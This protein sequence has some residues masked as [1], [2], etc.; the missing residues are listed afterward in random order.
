[1]GSKH[2][3][4]KDGDAANGRQHEGVKKKYEEE[5][6]KIR[7]Q[8]FKR[9]GEPHVLDAAG[10]RDILSVPYLDIDRAIENPNTFVLDS[11]NQS[12]IFTDAS[13]VIFS[14]SDGTVD[15]KPTMA[16]TAFSTMPLLPQN[17]TKEEL[18]EQGKK[19][20]EEIK[21]MKEKLEDAKKENRIVEVEKPVYEF[22]PRHLL[23]ASEVEGTSDAMHLLDRV[24]KAGARLK[25][26]CAACG[27]CLH[28]V[29][30]IVDAD[31]L[32]SLMRQVRESGMVKCRE[33]DAGNFP[34]VFQGKLVFACVAN[35]SMRQARFDYPKGRK[36]GSSGSPARG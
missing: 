18:E 2:D 35:H 13:S 19:I 28:E 21:S 5:K 30:R 14:P 11:S 8:F 15:I 24:N 33:C 9:S 12:S 7:K 32:R 16:P 36:H 26:S 17:A 31:S 6:Q 10:L 4:K 22:S 27:H 23:E 29:T 3:N 1:M 25:W 34:F 20:L